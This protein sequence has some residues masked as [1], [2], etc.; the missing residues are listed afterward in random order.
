MSCCKPEVGV[1]GN[2]ECTLEKPDNVYLSGCVTEF[3]NFVQEHAVSLGAAGLILAFIQVS[4]Y[5]WWQ[6]SRDKIRHITWQNIW[7]FHMKND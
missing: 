4:H 3:G 1:I 2:K 7:T 5:F 6:N